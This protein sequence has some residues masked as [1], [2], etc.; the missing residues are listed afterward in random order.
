MALLMVYGLWWPNRQILFM[1][2]FPMR[3]WT[4]VLIT[5][6]VEIVSV[7]A[8]WDTIANLAHLGG[9][10]YGY[11][12][13]RATPRIA[14][15]IERLSVVREAAR[16]S[17]DRRLDELLEKVHRQGIHSLAWRERRFLKRMSGRR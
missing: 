3:V 1:F 7:I 9:L 8:P 13:V 5:I 4:L 17:D 12:I 16:A 11:L 2:L 6:A 10:L 15:R 14:R